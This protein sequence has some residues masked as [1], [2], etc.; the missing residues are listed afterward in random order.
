MLTEKEIS[1]IRSQRLARIATVSKKLQPD[2]APVGFEFDGTHFF[3]RGF[4]ITRTFK[5][6]NV[7]AGNSQVALVIDDLASVSPWMARGIT[8][9]GI[10]EVEEAEG[11]ARLRIT[12]RRSW[13][14]GIEATAFEDGKPVSRKSNHE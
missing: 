13:S 7:M 14:W 12:P 3:I 8:I 2:V 11:K 4:D 10:A 9:H 1:Y 6:K 5:Y